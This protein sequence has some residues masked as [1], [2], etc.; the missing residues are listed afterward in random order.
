MCVCVC[1]SSFLP[2]PSS[3][4][5]VDGEAV[6]NTLHHFLKSCQPFFNKLDT[7]ARSTAFSPNPLACNVFKKVLKK[8]KKGKK[9]ESHVYPCV[10]GQTCCKCLLCCWL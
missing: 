2:P 9:N 6:V 4:L 7:V 3:H 8:K 5:Q 1:F 10:D